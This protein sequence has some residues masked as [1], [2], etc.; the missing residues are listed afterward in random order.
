MD[1]RPVAM[2]Q[3]QLL[4]LEGAQWQRQPL[5]LAVLHFLQRQGAA[6][7]TVFRGIAGFGTHSRVHQATLVD[8]GA[9]LPLLL[10]WIDDVERVARLLPQIEAMVGDQGLILQYPVMTHPRHRPV[11]EHFPRDLRVRDVMTSDVMQ[12]EP[13]VLLRDVAELFLHGGVRTVPVV[14]GDRHV[15]GVITDGDLLRRGKLVLPLSIREALRHDEAETAIDMATTEQRAS[16]VMTRDVVVV[17]D[18]LPLGDTIDVMAAR[19][20]K[21]LPV[22]DG[23]GRLAGIVSRSDILQ[24]LAHVAPHAV[25]STHP[26]GA[27]Q[28]VGDVMQTEVPVVKVST[29]LVEVLEDLAGIEQRR[30]VVV[31]EEGHVAGI[32]TDGDLLRRAGAEERSGI[33]QTLMD[34]LRGGS[35]AHGHQLKLA[36]RAAASVMTSPVV[37]VDVD[38]SPVEALDLMIEHH[39]KRLP[40]VDAEG[41]LVGLIGR[42]GVLRALSEAT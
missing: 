25:P 15:V 10:I 36:G 24:T 20:F 9:D 12:V 38:A 23:S 7:A 8:I 37:T 31:D 14:D 34:R 26:S 16:D 39:I 35:S 42:A 13:H 22:V 33:L 2:Q 40:V 29:P 4:M 27:A 1:D 3:V 19:G 28:R 32:I 30:V 18:D 17:R 5:Y 21:R 11:L 41:H 6:G